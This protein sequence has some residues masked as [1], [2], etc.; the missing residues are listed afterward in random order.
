METIYLNFHGI[1]VKLVSENSNLVENIRRDF[2]FFL[3]DNPKADIRI[4]GMAQRSDF[5]AIPHKIPFFRTRDALCFESGGIKYINY[6]NKALS[7][8]NLR[9]ETCKIICDEPH[10]LHEITYITI[11]SR[12]GEK[13]DLKSIHRI[14]ALGFSYKDNGVLCLSPMYGGKTTLGLGLLNNPYVKLISDDTPLINKGLELL[15]F[16]T[17]IGIKTVAGLGIPSKFLREI[18]RKRFGRKVLIDIEYFYPKIIQGGVPLKFIFISKK[19]N[20]TTPKIKRAGLPLFIFSL[21]RD[22]ILARGIAQVKEYFIQKNIGDI[23]L[24]IQL[25]ISRGIIAIA[26]LRKFKPHILY[27]SRDL[28]KNIKLISEFLE[29]EV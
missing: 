20:R 2:S 5:K 9:E 4:E 13:L 3:S 18:T 26:I 14:H 8:Y 29:R 16:P 15:S 12:V 25:F 7:V 27:L 19:V 6:L 21:S 17:R 28:D 22:M 11:L 24:K 1:G 10:L 23:L